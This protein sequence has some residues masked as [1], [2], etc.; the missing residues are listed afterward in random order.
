MQDCSLVNS[1]VRCDINSE[2]PVWFSFAYI[3]QEHFCRELHSECMFGMATCTGSKGEFPVTSPAS[4][5]LPHWQRCS[6]LSTSMMVDLVKKV[7]RDLKPRWSW[8]A[9]K[10][11]WNSRT[12]LMAP[13]FFLSS[14]CSTMGQD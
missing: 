2:I 13:L 1:I 12:I 14:Y 9:C 11:Y 4:T 7:S 5:T 8:G 3:D 10:D 6:S